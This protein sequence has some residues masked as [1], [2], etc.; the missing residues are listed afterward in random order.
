[1]G[2]EGKPGDFVYKI[3][4]NWITGPDSMSPMALLPEVDIYRFPKEVRDLKE[5]I[6]FEK[7]YNDPKAIINGKEIHL[8][9]ADTE[10]LKQKGMMYK[11]SY[12]KNRGML[13]LWDDIVP[14]SMWMRN[15][16]LPLDIIYMV[17]GEV[18]DYDKDVQPC[19]DQECE[20]YGNVNANQVIELVS[21]G[22]DNY[23]I[24]VGDKLE[25]IDV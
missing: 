23:N 8:D 4:V 11:T 14:I 18:V 20:T 13:F 3:M 24:K 6:N 25:L 1:M 22:V 19:E 7:P 2:F 5:Q 16:F 9:I 10:F 15:T 12:P 21:G 17:D